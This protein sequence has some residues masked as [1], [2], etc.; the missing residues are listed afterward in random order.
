MATASL[1]KQRFTFLITKG[2]PGTDLIAPRRQRS[3]EK[4]KT[5]MM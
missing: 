5:G 2:E 3:Q 4:K 1:R